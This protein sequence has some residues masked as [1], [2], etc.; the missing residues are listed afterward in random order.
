MSTMIRKKEKSDSQNYH[1]YRVFCCC[2]RLFVRRGI[3][4]VELLIV[5]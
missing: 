1:R 2:V 4:D 5:S 3:C